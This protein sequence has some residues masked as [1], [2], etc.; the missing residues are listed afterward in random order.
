MFIYY[1]TELM[2][3]EKNLQ[4]QEKKACSMITEAYLK[5]ARMSMKTMFN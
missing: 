1:A 4:R 3:E 2:K 5:E